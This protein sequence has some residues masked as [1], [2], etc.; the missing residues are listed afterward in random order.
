VRVET[1]LWVQGTASGK[2]SEGNFL[3]GVFFSGILCT[4]AAYFS[5]DEN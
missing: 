1:T 3:T 5:I 2:A 4:F